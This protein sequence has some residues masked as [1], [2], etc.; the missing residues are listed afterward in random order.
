M[1]VENAVYLKLWLTCTTDVL[2]LASSIAL[3]GRWTLGN[4]YKDP[5]TSLHVIPSRE[6][7]IDVVIF[8]FL[9]YESKMAIF[10]FGRKIGLGNLI[11]ILIKH[12]IPSREYSCHL[13]GVRWSHGKYQYLLDLQLLCH[14]ILFLIMARVVT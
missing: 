10:S 3:R 1:Y 9:W 7:N 12:M 13:I 8:A 6:F 4:A 14:V 5:V 11:S 2:T